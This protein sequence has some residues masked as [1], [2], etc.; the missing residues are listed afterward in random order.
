MNKI[1]LNEI[2]KDFF[3]LN[4]RN[5]PDWLSFEI[6]SKNAT[7]RSY[8]WDSDVFTRIRLCELQI[9]N[10]FEA[11]ALVIYPNSDYDYP[12][13]GTEYVNISNK[14][15]LAAIDFH[16][17]SDNIEYLKLLSEFPDIKIEYSKF[18]DLKEFFSNKM[19]I[20]KQR[21]DFYNEYLI[22]VKNYLHQ[23]KKL[24]SICNKSSKSFETMHQKYNYH[25]ASNN[26]AFGILKSYFG[27][28]FSQKYITEFL[29]ST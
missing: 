24:I 25:M 2:I 13:F 20:K 23:Y 11:E 27:K 22:W 28:D 12:I 21:E 4:Q 16:P 19:W 1:S 29:F 3:V 15:H 26:P 10:K 7:L 5:L 14:R 6:K 8:L 17:I 9:E 18:Y